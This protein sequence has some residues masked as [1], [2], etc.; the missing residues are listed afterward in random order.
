MKGMLFQI[1]ELK[2]LT[3]KK[4]GKEVKSVLL[5]ASTNWKSPESLTKISDSLISYKQISISVANIIF[6]CLFICQF[7]KST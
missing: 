1:T 7:A 2:T 3:S 4:R 5:Q 6:M